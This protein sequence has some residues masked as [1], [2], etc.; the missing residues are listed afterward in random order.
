M[1]IYI[2]SDHSGLI[3]YYATKELAIEAAK[4]AHQLD[5]GCT[6]ESAAE[7]FQ[8]YWDADCHLEEVTVVKDNEE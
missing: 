7:S 4:D 8:P 5:L 2:L 6:P 1:K 3:G